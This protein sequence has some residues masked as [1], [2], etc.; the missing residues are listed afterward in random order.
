MDAVDPPFTSLGGSIPPLR[1]WFNEATGNPRFIAL[2]SP[3]CDPCLQGATVVRED[4]VGAFH[5]AGFPVSLLWIPVL[6]GDTPAAIERTVAGFEDT[7]VFI[8]SDS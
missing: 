2:L 5:E 4:V 3:T 6:A 1:P 8:D 7:Q